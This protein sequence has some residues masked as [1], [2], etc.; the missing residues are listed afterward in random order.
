MGKGIPS[1]GPVSGK[2]YP[3]Y[4]ELQLMF[5]S[6][7]IPDSNGKVVRNEVGEIMLGHHMR[8]MECYIMD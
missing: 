8:G 7:E 4:R 3:I 1:K 5:C 2:P 6:T